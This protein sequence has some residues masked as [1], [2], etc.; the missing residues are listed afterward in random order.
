VPLVRSATLVVASSTGVSSLEQRSR[1]CAARLARRPCRENPAPLRFAGMEGT[2]G[3]V[4]VRRPRYTP[5]PEERRAQRIADVKWRK[6]RPSVRRSLKRDFDIVFDQCLQI[7]ACND[8]FEG[9]FGDDAPRD[10][11]KNTAVAFFNDVNAMLIDRWV[12]L[13]YKLGDAANS[14]RSAKRRHNMSVR[15]LNRSLKAAGLRTSAIRK[16]TAG[17]QRYWRIIRTSRNKVIAH[18]CRRTY[19]SR[20]CIGAHPASE[21]W[22]FLR[23]VQDYCDHVGRALRRFKGDLGSGSRGDAGILLRFLEDGL[24]LHTRIE[25]GDREEL[26]RR[27]HR[28]RSTR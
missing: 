1:W 10:L 26:D 8:L 27:L 12:L 21:I 16:A 22:D 19:R 23:N 25:S 15:N 18:A 3:S 2:D 5:S 28:P 14:A 11:L 6:V 20:R 7:V 17:I 13:V 9:L 4:W 24:E